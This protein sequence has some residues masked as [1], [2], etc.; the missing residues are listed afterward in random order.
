VPGIERVGKVAGPLTEGGGFHGPDRCAGRWHAPCHDRQ[1]FGKLKAGA[2][3][4]EAPVHAP[5]K[6]C[7]TYERLEQPCQ[8]RNTT[9]RSPSGRGRPPDGLETDELRESQNFVSEMARRYDGHR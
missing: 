2:V 3:G 8:S 7:M 5:P 4:A 1:G 6:I 9:G